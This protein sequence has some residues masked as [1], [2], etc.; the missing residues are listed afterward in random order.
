[1]KIEIVKFPGRVYEFEV[2]SG[3]TINDIVALAQRENVDFAVDGG[4]ITFNNSS[5]SLG[6]RLYN[7]GRIVIAKRVKGNQIDARIAKFPGRSF[8]F[9]VDH[10]TTIGQLINLARNPESGE[11]IGDTDGYEI[12]L[13]GRVVS[14]SDV[15]PDSGATQRV[16][17]FKKVKGNK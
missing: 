9:M 8:S 1:M 3:S 5:A 2:E 11:G 4:D 16:V 17:L 6:T 14:E 15:L 13:D 12:K 7:A 10:G